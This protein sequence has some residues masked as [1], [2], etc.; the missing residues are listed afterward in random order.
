MAIGDTNPILEDKKIYY[1]LDTGITKF[2]RSNGRRWSEEDKACVEPAPLVGGPYARQGEEWVDVGRYVVVKTDL[3]I[4][5]DC[6]RVLMH[7]DDDADPYKDECGNIWVPTGTPTLVDSPSKFGKSLHCTADNYLTLP[8]ERSIELGG[9][10]FTIDYWFS[11]DRA[12]V[13]GC[14]L[15]VF[16]LPAMIVYYTQLRAHNAPYWDP[17]APGVTVGTMNH[18]GLVYHHDDSLYQ[19]FLNGNLVAER[20]VIY[21]R[22]RPKI[23][24]G[25]GGWNEQFFGTID[26]LSIVD[27]IAK[28]SGNFNVPDSPLVM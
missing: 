19:F 14:S 25:D 5:K 20:G 4:L 28:W 3:D 18:V 26:E 6:T 12:Q 16:G 2:G 21:E 11:I 7:F 23:V 15:Q 9:Q 27:G 8:E 10:D 24:I 13:N 1:D 17:Y 22:F